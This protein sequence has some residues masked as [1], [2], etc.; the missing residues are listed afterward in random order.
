[1][2]RNRNRRCSYCNGIEVTIHSIDL[3]I[4]KYFISEAGYG[5][6]SATSV[7]R[8]GDNGSCAC[9]GSND[10]ALICY[11][12]QVSKA[13]IVGKVRI[14]PGGWLTACFR[15]AIAAIGGLEEGCISERINNGIWWGA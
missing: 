1:M 12:P 7:G 2:N 8:S 13:R 10:K 6:P 3:Q 11:S 5:G 15:P 9:C 14:T 4:G